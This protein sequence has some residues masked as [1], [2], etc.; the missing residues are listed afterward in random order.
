MNTDNYL[1]FC[2]LFDC[3]YLDKG[4]ALYRSMRRQMENFILYIFAFDDKCFEVLSDMHLKN[5]ILISLE[6]IMDDQ[7]RQKKEERTRAEFCWT[8]TSVVI[9]HV[10]LRYQEKVCTYVDADIYFFANPNSII[11]QIVDHGCSVGVAPHG[12]ERSYWD[13][14]QRINNGRY[15]IHF[16]TFFHTEDGLRVLK[17]WKEDCFNWC[18][19]RCEDGKM[20]D[21]KYTDKWKIK[22]S[23]VHEIKNPGAGVAPW[24]VHLYAYRGRKDGKILLGYGNEIFPLVFYHFEGLK[25]LDDGSVFLNLWKSNVFGL[26]EKVNEIY[27]EYFRQIGAIRRY[28][29][30]NYGV[31][32]EDM[33]ADKKAFLNPKCS[34]K[35]FCWNRG[36]LGGL[37]DWIR[38]RNNNIM[39]EK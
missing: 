16:N 29:K 34:L 11:K 14:E 2:T 19:N 21:Q 3:N 22:Y 27:G 36:L 17:E 7:L 15:C 20:G 24:N 8:C 30:N 26:K 35:G 12:F 1:I 5:V 4:L 32:F 39:Q 18:Y 38:F 23:C 9:E 28:L 6:E 33:R 13:V 31:S 25:Y 37:R 10:L